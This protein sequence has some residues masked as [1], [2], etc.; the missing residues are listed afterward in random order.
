MN[1]R[2]R[3][4]KR[5]TVHITEDENGIMGLMREC[6]ISPTK[7]FSLVVMH[8]SAQFDIRFNVNS[9]KIDNDLENDPEFQRYIKRAV[10]SVEDKS[11]WDDRDSPFVMDSVRIDKSTCY[12]N[13]DIYVW[14]SQVS[15]KGS[16]VMLCGSKITVKS[17]KM[18]ELLKELINKS[19]NS[20]LCDDGLKERVKAAGVELMKKADEIVN[21]K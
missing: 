5:I 20:I 8:S 12:S 18:K 17:L 21:F 4:N 2:K 14:V 11:T 9:D 1:K 15:G 19:K 7:H 10:I 6:K 13:G 3:T 16:G